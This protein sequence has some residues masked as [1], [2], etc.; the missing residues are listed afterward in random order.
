MS[1][2][3]IGDRI[4]VIALFRDGRLRPLKFRWHGR[5]HNIERIN[6]QWATDEGRARLSHFSVITAEGPDAYELIYNCDSRNWTLTQI[7]LAG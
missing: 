4:E 6:G 5:V 3:E 1:H 2:E 7:S